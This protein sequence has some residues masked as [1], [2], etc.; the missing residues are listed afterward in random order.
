MIRI[1]FDCNKCV[2]RSMC[3]FAMQTDAVRK[4]PSVDNVF[5]KDSILRL[6]LSCSCYTKE[7]EEE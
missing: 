4:I 1:N 7:N 2:Y 5:G 3:K 6:S